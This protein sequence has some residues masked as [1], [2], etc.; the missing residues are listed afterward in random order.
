[1]S[2]V[3]NSAGGGSVTISE[4]NTASNR[5]LTLPDNTG[6][7]ISTA[8]SGTVSPTMLSQKLT[9]MTAQTASGSSVDFTSIP[10]WVKR[11]TVSVTGLS[12]AAA[13]AFRIRLGTSSG[14]VTSGYL[15]G[16]TAL[17][18]APGISISSQT[19]G[20]AAGSTTSAST[21]VVGSFVI[22]LV[23]GN[24]WVCNGAFYRTVDGITGFNQGSISLAATLDRLSMVATTSTFDAGTINVMYEG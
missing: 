24:T 6:N 12:F 13:G 1:M 8:D 18:T 21:T 14:L 4:P 2:I 3:L 10:S 23:D 7:L 11:I 5:T 16:S 15:T 22:T 20:I 17:T 19:D 9:Q